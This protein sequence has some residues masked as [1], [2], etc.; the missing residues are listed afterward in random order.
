VVSIDVAI[1]AARQHS[2]GSFGSA[3]CHISAV[4]PS[5]SWARRVGG[6][7]RAGWWWSKSV[8]DG[9]PSS[10]THSS[11]VIVMAAKSILVIIK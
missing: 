11:R 5:P 8:A 4:P 7:G 1:V 10:R 3:S 2:P 6:E 9:R